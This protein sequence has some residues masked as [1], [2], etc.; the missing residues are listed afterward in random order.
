MVEYSKGDSLAFSDAL[1]ILDRKLNSLIQ[2]WLKSKDGKN[3]HEKLFSQMV[4]IRPIV[5]LESRKAVSD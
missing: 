5:D 1:Q 4:Y 2:T 3:P